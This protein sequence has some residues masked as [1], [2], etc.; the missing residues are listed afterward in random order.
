[1][2]YKKINT[3]LHIILF[4][5]SFY[6]CDRVETNKRAH[7][8]VVRW[9]VLAVRECLFIVDSRVLF[10]IKW[11]A[12]IFFFRFIVRMIYTDRFTLNL[13]TNRQNTHTFAQLTLAYIQN[14]GDSECACECRWMWIFVSFSLCSVFSFSLL[15][16]VLYL[17]VI[18]CIF[19][20]YFRLHSRS[21][22]I[23]FPLHC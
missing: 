9:V 19:T 10:H 17:S 2:K 7:C 1:M 18:F 15:F 20:S 4:T 21:S 14:S 12:D 13:A 11:L 3:H 5:L 16:S 22:E 23:L 6:M 8:S